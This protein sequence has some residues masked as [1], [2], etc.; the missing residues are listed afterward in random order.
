MIFER[1]KSGQKNRAAF[2][3]VDLVC[4]VEGGGGHSS[5]SPDALYWS[6]VF[7][8]IRP[9]AKIRYLP[10][11]GKPILE[12]L[13]NQIV[14]QDIENTIVAIDS[15]YDELLGHRL[16]DPRVLY[17]YG[18]SWENDLF[19]ASSLAETYCTLARTPI[20]EP[21]IGN[22]IQSALSSF[23]KSIRRASLADFLALSAGAS[24]LPREGAGRV[25]RASGGAP[26]CDY[27]EVIKLTVA[28]N[29]ITRTG[30]TIEYKK[31]PHED[32]RH[33]VGH[34]LSHA[35]RLIMNCCL[36]KFHKNTNHSLDHITDVAANVFHVVL[37][38]KSEK[39]KYYRNM[40]KS[41]PV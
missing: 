41:I 18:Y 24:V 13:A 32:G 31:L 15:D 11:G 23:I 26:Y 9:T 35:V 38:G 27:K 40:I 29:K 12:G 5:G 16:T 33:C 1:S 14:E 28:A 17:T 20:L 30:R 10:R 36:R 22:F 3:G 7:K 4:Y 21:E 6:S 39:A 8:A 37:K 25:V 2:L 19:C 34:V